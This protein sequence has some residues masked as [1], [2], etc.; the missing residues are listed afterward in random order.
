MLSLSFQ[1]HQAGGLCSD[2]LVYFLGLPGDQGA[3]TFKKLSHLKFDGLHTLPQTFRDVL[4]RH[5]K[6]LRIVEFSHLDQVGTLGT[7][8]AEQWITL[9][10]TLRGLKLD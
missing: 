3:L 4:L 2:Q 5:A 7:Y 6:T 1:R 10:E 9:V 8:E